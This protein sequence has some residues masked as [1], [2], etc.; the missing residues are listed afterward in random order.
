M[1]NDTGFSA[2]SWAAKKGDKTTVE[3]LLKQIVNVNLHVNNGLASLS[4]AAK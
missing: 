1:N 2:L 4:W 3:L